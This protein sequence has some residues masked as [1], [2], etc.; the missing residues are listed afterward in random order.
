MLGVLVSRADDA[1]V[2]IGEHLLDIESWTEHTDDS[3]SDT[4]GGGTVYRADGV[5]LREFGDLHLRLDRPAD[6]FGDIDLLAVASKHAGKTD[7]LLTAH[8]TGNFGPADHGGEDDAV[9]WACPNAHA[10]ALDA[11]AEHAPEEY[12]VGMEC[13][14]HGPTEVGVPSMFVEV[15]SSQSEWDDPDAARAV[16]QA[17]LDLRVVAPDRAPE[18]G[19]VG[20]SHRRHLLGIGGGHY[21]P[22]FERVVRETDWAVGHIAADWGLDAMGDL[23]SESSQRVLADAF[24]TSRAAYALVDG[25][26]PDVAAAVERAGGRVVSETWVRETDGVQLGFVDRVESAVTS[27]ADG[28]RFGDPAA[29]YDGE[30]VVESLP[31]DLLDEARGIDREATYDLL[32]AETLAFCT[33]QGGTRPTNPVVFAAG[34]DREG[35]VDALADILRERYDSVRRAGDELIAL[36]QAFSAEKARTLG[37]PEGPKFGKLSSGHPVE[38]DGKT[39]PPSTVS[40]ERERRFPLE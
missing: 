30:F 23:D 21:A 22:R 34:A 40:D 4:D 27:V 10:R 37:V 8:H 17:I 19:K 38:V 36:E 14:H 16:A 12:E 25:D 33:D 18:D 1:S 5:E 20:D 11:L 15:G 7:E 6:A 32:V 28:L 9:A 39:I 31:T 29:G 26:R 13:T 3:R 24:E 2:H 35:V